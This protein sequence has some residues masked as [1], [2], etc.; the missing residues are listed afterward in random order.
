MG[1]A[2]AVRM[3][4]T[5]REIRGLAKQSVGAGQVRRLLAIASVLDGYARIGLRPASPRHSLRDMD[6]AI[7]TV[8]A[9]NLG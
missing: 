2:I 5:S 4:Y 9:C 1:R 7:P 8:R 6:E 3:D